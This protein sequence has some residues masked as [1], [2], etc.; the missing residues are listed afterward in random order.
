ML[1][2]FSID[3]VCALS[4]SANAQRLDPGLAA[5]QTVGIGLCAQTCPVP[6]RYKVQQIVCANVSERL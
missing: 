3:S 5:E 4:Y 6:I 1:R 2:L